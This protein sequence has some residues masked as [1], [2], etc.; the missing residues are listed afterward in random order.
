MLVQL[1]IQQN[2]CT[3]TSK[4]VRFSKTYTIKY[5]RHLAIALSLL[6]LSTL[7]SNVDIDSLVIKVINIVA[8][9]VLFKPTVPPPIYIN[10]NTLNG[11]SS[12][13]LL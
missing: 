4:K 13:L 9:Q 2:A 3:D 5:P 11:G 1:L 10:I 7:T 12:F 6:M 8:L